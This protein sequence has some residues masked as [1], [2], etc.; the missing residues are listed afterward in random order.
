MNR[1]YSAHLFLFFV[2]IFS[3]TLKP[4]AAAAAP[5]RADAS[6]VDLLLLLDQGD[7]HADKAGSEAISGMLAQGVLS[8]KQMIV[9]TGVLLHRV[10]AE[11]EL[12]YQNS[13]DP[14]NIEHALIKMSK[15]PHAMHGVYHY[16]AAIELAKTKHKEKMEEAKH[17]HDRLI[18][19]LKAQGKAQEAL[20]MSNYEAQRAFLIQ[21]HSATRA[22]IEVHHAEE[23]ELLKEQGKL[24]QAQHD[25]TGLKMRALEESETS[26]KALAEANMAVIRARI[27][28]CEADVASKKLDL[29]HAREAQTRQRRTAGTGD[30]ATVVSSDAREVEEDGGRVAVNFGDSA[31]ASHAETPGSAAAAVG[32]DATE[33]ADDLVA[34]LFDEAERSHD[35]SMSSISGATSSARSVTDEPAVFGAGTGLRESLAEP[36]AAVVVRDHADVVPAHAGAGLPMPDA[37]PA[38]DAPVPVED[39]ASAAEK[40]EAMSGPRM[41]QFYEAAQK[42][43]SGEWYVYRH[44]SA[45]LYLLVPI[46]YAQGMLK[47]RAENSTEPTIKSA[48]INCTCDMHYLDELG[49]SSDQLRC[50]DSETRSNFTTVQQLLTVVQN[51]MVKKPHSLKR[52][53][54]H[55]PEQPVHL[56]A[57]QSLFK[58]KEEAPHVNLYILWS[59]HGLYE[60]F[61][62][63]AANISSAY[64]ARPGTIRGKDSSKIAYLGGMD[65]KKSLRMLKFFQEHCNVPFVH[66]TSCFTGGYMQD[67]IGRYLSAAEEK[68]VRGIS[69]FSKRRVPAALPQTV[70]ALSNYFSNVTFMRGDI[71]F[72][73][74][75]PMLHDFFTNPAHRKALR[76]AVLGQVS[77]DNPLRKVLKLLHHSSTSAV[78]VRFPGNLHFKVVD[79]KG[80]LHMVTFNDIE[81]LTLKAGAK[82]R[83]PMTDELKIKDAGLILRDAMI[84][85]Q[86]NLDGPVPFMSINPIMGLHTIAKI[87]TTLKPLEFF[88]SS[89]VVLPTLDS[90]VISIGAVECAEDSRFAYK[91][92]GKRHYAA[93]QHLGKQ[94]L[95]VVV[96]RLALPNNG[97]AE[98]AK[99]KKNM[100][101]YVTILFDADSLK[102]YRISWKIIEGKESHEVELLSRA[103]AD[104]ERV[105]IMRKARGVALSVGEEYSRWYRA[106]KADR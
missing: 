28:V 36:A 15:R 17:T 31:I 51:S 91:V 67:M 65:A 29:K 46:A 24:L 76:E 82:G 35:E 43:I 89:F 12:F 5:M 6:N 98:A 92:D 2:V 41:Y 3:P 77:E 42:L 49:F 78:A 40:V 54:W 22:M 90:Q 103:D 99:K 44:H 48:V 53:L 86:I 73:T 71:D 20:I 101:I 69:S 81:P 57:L 11:A 16:E 105:R 94:M 59:G 18:E 70:V 4:A 80:D 30:D 106:V 104:S 13:R 1:S 27:A 97:G 52:F 102:S 32:S 39:E 56:E 75:F 87:T 58:T 88:K 23:L 74:I 50:V 14:R 34:S 38:V 19:E 66:I 93:D 83:V 47:A 61:A 100:D 55:L 10:L 8:G 37:E 62:H 33:G 95:N 45:D 84:I 68:I 26:R 79:L 21:T 60:D 72:A 9:T 25:L 64:S 7:E 85:H 63:A 96:E